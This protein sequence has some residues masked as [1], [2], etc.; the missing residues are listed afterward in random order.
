MMIGERQINQNNKKGDHPA[1][2]N[3]LFNNISK[4]GRGNFPHDPPPNFK[5]IGNLPAAPPEL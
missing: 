1:K 2:E 5:V 4:K 3:L